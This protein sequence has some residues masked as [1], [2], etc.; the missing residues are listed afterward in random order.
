MWAALENLQTSQKMTVALAAT[1][2]KSFLLPIH[3]IYVFSLIRIHKSA[4][5][6]LTSTALQIRS[7]WLD[8]RWCY[9]NLH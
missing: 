3:R 1:L 8:P 5:I 7:R 4:V 2:Q 6:S 9:G